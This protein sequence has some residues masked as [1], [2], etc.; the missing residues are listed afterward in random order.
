M[1]VYIHRQCSSAARS[2]PE[3]AVKNATFLESDVSTDVAPPL[4]C[5][6]RRITGSCIIFTFFFNF[7]LHP[8]RLVKGNQRLKQAPRQTNHLVQTT[9]L[10]RILTYI[11]AKRNPSARPF[12]VCGRIPFIP[13]YGNLLLRLFANENEVRNQKILDTTRCSPV[14]WSPRVPSSN[15]LPFHHCLATPLQGKTPSN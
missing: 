2:L 8:F 13:A 1:V 7:F 4:G 5:S 12:S 14:S 11:F 15:I 3:S 6:F 10:S 9:P